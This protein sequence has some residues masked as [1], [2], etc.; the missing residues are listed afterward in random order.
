MMPGNVATSS[1]FLLVPP[2]FDNDTD[3]G[4][5]PPWIGDH[6]TLWTCVYI[7]TVIVGGVLLN[8]TV[9]YRILTARFNG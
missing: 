1:D 6:L 4:E 9:L 7:V 5:F 8:M 3:Q 2:K